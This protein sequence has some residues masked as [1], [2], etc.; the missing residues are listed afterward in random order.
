MVNGIFIEHLVVPTGIVFSVKFDVI[1]GVENTVVFTANIDVLFFPSA[2][3][4]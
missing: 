4:L 3:Q 2:K 1:G